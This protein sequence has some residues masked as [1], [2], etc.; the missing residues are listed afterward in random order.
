[1]Q[2]ADERLDARLRQIPASSFHDLLAQL[3]VIDTCKGW[4]EGREG[5]ALA[6]LRRVP[7]RVVEIA[8]AASLRIGGMNRPYAEASPVRSGGKGVPTR[9]D[10]A[11]VSGYADLL[12]LVYEGYRDMT[13]GEDLI[14]QFHARVLKYSSI[15]HGHRGKYKTVSDTAQSYLRRKMDGPALRSAAPDLTPRAM[16]VATAWAR[17]RLGSGEFHPLLVIAGFVL[18][19]LAIRPFV[20]GNGRVSRMLSNLLLLQSGYTFVPYASLEHVIADR[21]AE[22]YI[23]LRRSQAN[24]HLPHPDISPW[25]HAFLEVIRI[26]AGEARKLVEAR[27]DTALLSENQLEVLRLLEREGEVTNR[28]VCAELGMP[29]D[30]VKQ[31]LQRLAAL[32]LV[33]RVGAGRAVR[34]RKAHPQAGGGPR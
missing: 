28:L 6:E 4:W 7:R 27:P 26:Q 15:D 19:L 32:D 34:Y 18:E 21:W 2:A 13:F 14:L 12:R 17:L 33:T 11:H 10:A 9:A 31:V 20:N 8:A 5:K 25:L 30:T 23:A 3:S 29:R 24:A 16:A 22:Y 1:M